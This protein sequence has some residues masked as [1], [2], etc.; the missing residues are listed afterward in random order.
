MILT[1]RASELFDSVDE[2]LVELRSPFESGLGV[3]GEDEVHV[4]VEKS[5]GW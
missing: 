2:S 1:L 5:H 3:A 4:L